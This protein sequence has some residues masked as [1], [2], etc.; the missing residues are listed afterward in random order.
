LQLLKAAANWTAIA[1]GNARQHEQLRRLARQV[2][3]AQEEER[4]RLAQELHDEAG[5]A[6]TA[7]KFSLSLL[8]NDL[9]EEPAGTPSVRSYRQQ[10]QAAIDLTEETMKQLRLL[11]HGLR[12]PALSHF[13]LNLTLKEFCQDFSARIQVPIAYTGEELPAVPDAVSISFYRFLQE[14]LTNI[15]KHAEASEV[16]VTLSYDGKAISLEVIDDGKGFD[17]ATKLSS[18][19]PE[20]IGLLGMQE[21]FRIL[22]GDCQIESA[23][24][25]GTRLLACC[26]LPATDLPQPEATSAVA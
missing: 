8:Q 7:L 22:N 9:P 4:K 24:G 2:I 12:P 10:V 13:G 14:A 26:R 5:Q 17:P 21:R 11:S 3:S 25:K 19:R 16:Q 18:N 6:L 15:A 1:I 20:G 23:P